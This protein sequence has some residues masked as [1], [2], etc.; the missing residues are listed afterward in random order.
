MVNRALYWPVLAITVAS[1]GCSGF[2]L[3]QARQEVA[4]AMRAHSPARYRLESIGNPLGPGIVV[5]ARS[6]SSCQPSVWWLVASPHRAV[7]LSGPS[8][9][10]TPALPEL[11]DH[12]PYDHRD[13]PGDRAS[14]DEAIRREVCALTPG[15][16]AAR[17]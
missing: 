14:F 15:T 1:A 17:R 6:G 13:Q 16:V 5:F 3:R 4:A 9:A 11:D 10:L 12:T 8:Q 7:A 2:L